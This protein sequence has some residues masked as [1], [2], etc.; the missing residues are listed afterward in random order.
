MDLKEKDNDKGRQESQG[1]Q[2][3]PANPDSPD[4]NVILYRSL[5]QS[6]FSGSRKLYFL[7]AKT[8]KLASAVY[9]VTELLP[10]ENPLKQKVRRGAIDLIEAVIDFILSLRS[11][12]DIDGARQLALARTQEVLSL[13]R[14]ALSAPGASRMNFTL[15]E[16][17]YEDLLNESA[18]VTGSETAESLLSEETLVVA[19]PPDLGVDRQNFFMSGSRLQDGSAVSIK[20]SGLTRKISFSTSLG[21]DKHNVLNV[22]KD[23]QKMSVMSVMSAMSAKKNEKRDR[24]DSVLK[25]IKERGP[26]SIKEIAREIG[27]C[28]EKTIQRL[29]S[30]LVQ[31]GVI[32]KRGERRWSQYS[33][34]AQ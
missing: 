27:G 31:K 19:N 24:A 7:Y 16:R 32:Q 20:D 23:R 15:L 3:D 2:S 5:S 22:I 6:L 30:D 17:E 10:E 29:L 12:R 26:V 28:S 21:H 33:L 4:R 9:L 11:R 1:V 13:C 8:E 34:A 25:I 14:V 18:S